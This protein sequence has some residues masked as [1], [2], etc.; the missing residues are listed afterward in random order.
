MS[1][2]LADII[3]PQDVIDWLRRRLRNAAEL[4]AQAPNNPDLIT[5]A[6]SLETALRALEQWRRLR[7]RR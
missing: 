5:K 7:S 6:I 2:P 1:R 4:S 3:Q